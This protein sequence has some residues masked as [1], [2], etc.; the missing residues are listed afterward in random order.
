MAQALTQAAT[1]VSSAIVA[2][3]TPR[4]VPSGSSTS[5]TGIS[6]AKIIENRSKCYRQ[7]TE[8][9]NLRSQG[10]LSDED[11]SHEKDAIMAI[12]KKLV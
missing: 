11:Y 12:L 3:F 8:L 10:L 2:A 5:Q 6:P 7:L 4:S 1:Q 9:Q